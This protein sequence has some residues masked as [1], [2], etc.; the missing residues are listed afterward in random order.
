[1][2]FTHFANVHPQYRSRRSFARLSIGQCTCTSPTELLNYNTPSPSV[3]GLASYPSR[4]VPSCPRFAVSLSLCLHR[5]FVR[6][7]APLIVR[8]LA[9]SILPDSH[10]ITSLWTFAS[11]NVARCDRTK[12]GKK[13]NRTART[14]GV[15][16]ASKQTSRACKAIKGKIKIT[17]IRSYDHNEPRKRRK[18]VRYLPA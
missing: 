7:L 8:S 5:S 12:E 14:A 10:S 1:M 2:S 16:K 4:S 17:I 18:P 13:Q 11:K 9:A 15:N 3:S 6:S